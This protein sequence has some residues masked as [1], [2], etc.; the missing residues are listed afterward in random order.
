MFD[1]VNFEHECLVIRNTCESVLPDSEFLEGA[2][3]E[4]FEI[5]VWIAPWVVNDFVEF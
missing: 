2:T 3:A 4:R 1:P 5:I